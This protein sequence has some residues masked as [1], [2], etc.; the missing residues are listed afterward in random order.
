MFDSEL[1][2]D[3]DGWPGAAGDRTHQNQTSYRYAD[4]GS[5][6][7]NEVPFFVLPLPATWPAKFRI[8]MGD[9]AAVVFRDKLA[10]AVFADAG[11]STKLGEGSIELHRRVGVERLRPNGKVQDA[12]MDPGVITVVFPGTRLTPAPTN[13]TQLLNHIETNGRLLF[14][15]LGGNPL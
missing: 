7:A 9:L 13:Q 2:L 15:Q 3:T 4:R 11:R 12:G 6:N 5:S 10:F 14:Q 8:R 1:Q